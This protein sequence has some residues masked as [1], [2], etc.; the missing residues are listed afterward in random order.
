MMIFVLAFFCSLL[1]TGLMRKYALRANVIDI[2]NARSSH[3]L[4]TPR[5]G[6]VAIVITYI[7]ACILAWNAEML[8]TPVA[9]TV[10]CSGG[11]ISIIGFC[12]DRGHVSARWR[13]LV[14]FC[15]AAIALALLG[16]FPIFKIFGNAYSLGPIGYILGALG[17]VWILNLY[18]F[19]D[20]IDGIAGVEAITASGSASVLLFILDAPF[21][22]WA[23][24]LLLASA[25]F[26]FLVW[27]LPPAKI[28]MGDAG[29]GF[30]GF[31]LAILAILSSQVSAD[32]FW[33]WMILLGLFIVDSTT[34]LIRRLLRGEKVYEAHRNHAYQHAAQRLGRHLPVTMGV[35]L[36][37][38]VWLFPIAWFV[39][40]GRLDGL[41]ATAI[42]Y[43]PLLILAL[44]LQ[45]GI[46]EEK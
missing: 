25:V 14:H 30:L 29:S 24:P 43:I 5:G 34:T 3:S 45:A 15:A 32:L 21:Y 1:L 4:P 38:V 19:M 28:F 17:I 10:I 9:L 41:V 22:S 11:L 44:Y 36:I 23:M 40:T 7:T 31:I 35:V 8:P 39:A 12:D 20:G 46:H 16:G 6:G 42:A 37:N 27:N 13:L 2:P 26:G 33:S 18:N